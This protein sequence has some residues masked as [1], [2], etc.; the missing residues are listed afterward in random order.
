MEMQ[1]IRESPS[2]QRAEHRKVPLTNGMGVHVSSPSGERWMLGTPGKYH[3][4]HT[5][6]GLLNSEQALSP[7][8]RRNNQI[9]AKKH[10]HNFATRQN[11]NIQTQ[12]IPLKKQTT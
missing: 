5:K 3:N 8:K 10:Q 4:T 7:R 6:R 2:R 12:W 11:E 1:S 9:A